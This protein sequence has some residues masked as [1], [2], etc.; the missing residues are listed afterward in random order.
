MTEAEVAALLAC[1]GHMLTQAVTEG[2]QLNKLHTLSARLQADVPS[3]NESAYHWDCI[4][5]S[6]LATLTAFVLQ[7]RP[8]SEVNFCK[9]I[10][11]TI[12]SLPWG[13]TLNP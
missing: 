3:S 5:S 13:Q 8:A 4:N 10:P 11:G 7:Q 6:H 2:V 9:S 12:G 1:E